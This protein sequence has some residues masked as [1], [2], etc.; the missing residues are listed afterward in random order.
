MSDQPTIVQLA[1][2]QLRAYNLCDIEAFCEC[3]HRDVRVMGE[4][5]VVSREGLGDFRAAYARMFSEHDD[6]RATVSDRMVLGPHIVEREQWSR[7]IRATGE[8]L[9]GELLV[10]YTAQDERIRFVEFLR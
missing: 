8:R 2:R 5:G 7:V 10:R 4:D 6:V 9:G 1:D 3:F